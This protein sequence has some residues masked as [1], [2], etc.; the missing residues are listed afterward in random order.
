MLACCGVVLG[1]VL[2]SLA[3]DLLQPSDGTLLDDD[4]DDVRCV[5]RNDAR[6]HKGGGSPGIYRL[7]SG[8]AMPW[9]LEARS[10]RFEPKPPQHWRRQ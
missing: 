7:G 6:S 2:G 4:D 10:S 8:H 1:C 9:C 5:V 3:F